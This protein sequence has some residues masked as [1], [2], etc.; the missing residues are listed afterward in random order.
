V[1][2]SKKQV[3]DGSKPTEGYREKSE[4]IVGICLVMI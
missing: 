4:N 3:T 1:V 2:H